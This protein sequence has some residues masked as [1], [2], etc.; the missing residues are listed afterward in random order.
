MSWLS[1]CNL[2][3]LACLLVNQSI[4]A[5]DAVLRTQDEQAIRATTKAYREAIAKGDSKAVAEFW[6]PDGDFV[7]GQGSIHSVK[8]LT[9]EVAKAAGSGLQSEVKVTPSKIRFLTS[10][11]AVEDSTSEAELPGAKELPTSRGHF[12]AI[13]VKKDAHWHL[14]SLYEIPITMPVEPSLAEF[15][16]MVGTWTADTD[17]LELEATVKW[18]ATGTF[19]LRD[20]KVV[21]DGKVMLRGSQRI[22]MD[23]VTRR[24]KSWSFDS[25]GGYSEA[26]WTKDGDSWVGQGT[27]VLFDGRQSSA[28][29]VISFDGKDTYTRKVVAG[30]V[31]GEPIADQV[32]EFKRLDKSDR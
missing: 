22:G 26:I 29:T 24:L 12:H 2:L 21:R 18:N 30:R 8:E 16:W 6:T 28:T 31:Q 27:G 15:D 25:D 11:V 13:W 5:D 19:L 23:P 4:L 17:D 7:D 10:D 20:T 32:V 1:R 9:A 14:A 3:A